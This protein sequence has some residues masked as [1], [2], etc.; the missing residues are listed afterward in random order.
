MR[1]E[2]QAGCPSGKL[3]GE[4]LSAALAARLHARYA[5]GPVPE[6]HFRLTLSPTQAKRVCEYIRAHLGSDLGVAELADQVNLS[7]HY[8]STLFKKALGMPP[9][10]YV[11]QERIH[12]AQ[13]LLSIGRMD[14][15][16]LALN[17]GFSDQSHFSRAFRKVTGTTPTRYQSTQ[18]RGI[19]KQST[20]RDNSS[21]TGP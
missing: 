6:S 10:R 2:I 12:A 16:E 19:F 20:G 4:A 21:G 13:R 8:F 11:L 3:Y 9:H 7:P 17:L 18:R 5:R 15:S 1:E 14:I